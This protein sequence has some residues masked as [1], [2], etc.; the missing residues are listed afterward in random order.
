MV[1]IHLLLMLCFSP[2]HQFMSRK[3]WLLRILRHFWLAR[4]HGSYCASLRQKVKPASFPAMS[5][6]T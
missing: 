6:G 2:C 1:F 4:S 3:C 5:I